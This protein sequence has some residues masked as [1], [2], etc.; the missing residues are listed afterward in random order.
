MPDGT[1]D[2]VVVVA[3]LDPH[4]TRATILRLDMGALGLEPGDSFEAHDLITDQRWTWQRDTYVRLGPEVEP[5][6]VVAVG[7]PW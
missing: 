1:E 6:H 2:V 3:N 4:S 7:R 5:V